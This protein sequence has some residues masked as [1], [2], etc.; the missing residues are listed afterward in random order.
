MATKEDEI[1]NTDKPAKSDK[2]VK[3]KKAVKSDKPAKSVKTAKTKTVEKGAGNAKK[4]KP[5]KVEAAAKVDVTAKAEKTVK[6]IEKKNKIAEKLK[7]MG[8]MGAE[9]KSVVKKSNTMV[10]MLLALVVAVPAGMLV[11]YVAMPEQLNDMFSFFSD[12]TDDSSNDYARTQMPVQPDAGNWNQNQVPEWV[13]QQRAEMEKR[14]SSFERNNTDRF[15]ENRSSFQPPQWVKDRQALI[16]KEQE[17][18]QQEWAKRSA[19]PL[20]NGAPS[21]SSYGYLNNQAMNV[22]PQN[23]PPV[24]A[25][26]QNQ[27]R[28]YNGYAQANPYAYNNGAYYGPQNMP[29]GQ[30]AYPR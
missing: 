9:K 27:P 5:V 11:A 6:D 14:R 2:V 13:V 29:Y 22:Y 30:N 23:P 25:Y 20:H 16:Q 12:S 3:P 15:A 7:A 4:G 8:M 24:N 1:T 28:Y 26:P 19:P 18:Y 17:K 10:S 21:P